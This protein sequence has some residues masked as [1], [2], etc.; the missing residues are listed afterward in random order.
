MRLSL[1]LSAG[2]FLLLACGCGHGVPREAVSGTVTLDGKPL[3]QGSILFSPLAAG[4]SAGGEIAQGRFELIQERGPGT[5]NY[6]VE[7]N[8]WRKT[9]HSVYDAERQ[10][11]EE[12]LESIIPAQYNSQSELE[13]TVEPGGE[14]TFDFQLSSRR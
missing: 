2:C 12:M 1:F 13:V 5:S 10:A 3:E 14:N 9:G 7:I 11:H 8:A 6:R 4:P